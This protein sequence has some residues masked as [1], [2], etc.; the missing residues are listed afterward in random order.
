[1]RE[2]YSALSDA[3]FDGFATLLRAYA[4]LRQIVRMSARESYPDLTKSAASRSRIFGYVTGFT[5][6][7]SSKSGVAFKLW[8]KKCVQSKLTWARAKSGCLTKRSVKNSRRVSFDLFVH[9]P[10]S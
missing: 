5:G 6:I 10:L 2:K 7:M 4:S 3:V 8:P 9:T 1:M